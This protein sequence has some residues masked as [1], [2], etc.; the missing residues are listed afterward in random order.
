MLSLLLYPGFSLPKIII[1]PIYKLMF[2]LLTNE[3]LTKIYN[4]SFLSFNSTYIN[5]RSLLFIYYLIRP[6]N[7]LAFLRP[8]LMCYAIIK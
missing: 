3:L 6:F 8:G 2:L 7:V 4:F 5:P 1:Y